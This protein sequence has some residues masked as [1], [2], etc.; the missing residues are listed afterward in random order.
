MNPQTRL[1]LEHHTPLAALAG[2]YS[3][4]DSVGGVLAKHFERFVILAFA[5]NATG[6]FAAEVRLVGAAAGGSPGALVLGRLELA[7]ADD[8][9]FYALE[10]DAA[11]L[12]ETAAVEVAMSLVVT[13]GSADL[14]ATLF[15][16]GP[17][18]PSTSALGFA[19]GLSAVV[20]QSR[21]VGS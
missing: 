6:G 8:W 1:F 4:N 14:S 20:G 12:A 21:F 5:Q 11:A 10:V 15:G 3:G 2:N 19:D 9:G 16:V 13:A 7:E 18:Y 17:K